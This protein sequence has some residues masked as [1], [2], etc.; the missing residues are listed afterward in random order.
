MDKQ[1][2]YYNLWSNFQIPAYDELSVPDDA[3]M[4]YITYQVITDDLDMPVYPSGSL[5]YRSSTWND[6]DAKLAEIAAYIENLSPIRLDDGYM[7]IV[8]GTPFAQ[9]MAD[10]TDRTAKRY[11]INLA[12]EFFTKN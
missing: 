4:P 5:W 6:I 9:R 11:V 7:H 10:E 8:K 1:Q 3:Q 12:I 2:A